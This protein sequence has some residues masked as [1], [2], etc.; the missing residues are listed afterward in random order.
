MRFLLKAADMFTRR[1]KEDLLHVVVILKNH[2]LL[3]FCVVH[4]TVSRSTFSV[5]RGMQLGCIVITE[6]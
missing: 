1:K 3:P 4:R 6:F 5:I 2:V